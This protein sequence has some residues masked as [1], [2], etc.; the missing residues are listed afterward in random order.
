MTRLDMRLV[1]I[2]AAT[3]IVAALLLIELM[4]LS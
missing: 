4:S 3:A 1:A 2:G